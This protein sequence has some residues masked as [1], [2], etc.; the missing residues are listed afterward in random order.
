MKF[1]AMQMIDELKAKKLT[2]LLEG[3]ALVTWLEYLQTVIELQTG[4][5]ENGTHVDCVDE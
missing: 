4:T 2:T 3:E 5:G 1:A